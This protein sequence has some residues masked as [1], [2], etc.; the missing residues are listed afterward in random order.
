MPDIDYT[1]MAASCCRDC[2]KLETWLTEDGFVPLEVFVP[3]GVGTI[4]TYRWALE[5]DDR[6]QLEDARYWFIG[7]CE[8]N[9]IRAINR[10]IGCTKEGTGKGIMNKARTTRYYYEGID[11]Y[12]RFVGRHEHGL[13]TKEASDRW[14]L[15]QRSQFDGIKRD[16]ERL[17]PA[18]N[19]LGP[20][21]ITK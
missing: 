5:S 16:L 20:V 15:L 13:T 7:Y 2:K 11:A 17:F 18:V 10:G 3:D 6:R 12:D 19:L 1:V 21:V 8:C 14:V 4:F 9:P